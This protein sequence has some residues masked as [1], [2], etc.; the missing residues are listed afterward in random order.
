[1]LNFKHLIAAATVCVAA[2]G[3]AGEA[4]AQLK[5]EEFLTL[6]QGL[7]QAVRLQAGPLLGFAQGKNELPAD[8]ALRAERLS[9]LAKLAPMGWMKGTEALKGSETKPAAFTAAKFLPGF[10]ALAVEANRLAEIAKSGDAAA[11]KAQAGVVGGL[12][13]DCHKEFK[14]D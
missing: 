11:I 14:N 8:A 7:M 4:A 6:R 12:C 3:L 1:M 5:P 13:K 9:S 10:D 2:A